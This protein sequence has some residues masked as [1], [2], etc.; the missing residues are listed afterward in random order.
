LTQYKDKDYLYDNYTNKKLTTYQIAK[1]YNVT[2]EA[3]QYWMK[4]FNIP[5]RS[6]SEVVHL[7]KGNHCI[8]SPEAIEWLSG[9]LLGDGSLGSQSKYSALFQYCSKY[10]EYIEYVR[11]TLKS[12]GI[13]QSGRIHKQYHRD[14]DSYSYFYR[15]KAYVELLPIYKQWYPEGKKIVPKDIKLTSLTLR[16]WHIGD[17]CLR[18]R[19]H[20][21]PFIILST[22][23]FIVSDVEQLVNKLKNIGFIIKRQPSTNVIRVTPYSTKEFLN[24]IGKCPV[25][26]YQYKWA[27]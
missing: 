25:N 18:H 14:Y 17:G 19:E 9:E 3:I 10:L 26:C 16:Q 2:G 12:F 20:R 15:S 27:Y 1:L 5:C 23:G 6:K 13:K 24:Y 21:R 4:K 11:D 8:L 22:Y 7:A